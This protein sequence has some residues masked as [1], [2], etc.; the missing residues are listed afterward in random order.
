MIT[1]SKRVWN[2]L[3]WDI[4]HTVIPCKPVFTLVQP[5]P[6]THWPTNSSLLCH[7]ALLC[8][9]QG[10]FP[11]NWSSSF[12]VILA[13]YYLPPNTSLVLAVYHHASTRCVLTIS[14][15]F[16]W[17]QI[18]ISAVMSFLQLP[19]FKLR[20]SERNF[21]PGPIADICNVLLSTSNLTCHLL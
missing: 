18:P 1:V 4:Q 11:S 2:T 12:S 10:Q 5:M 21:C 7:T 20:I 13:F 9:L 17:Q 19:R 16:P 14:I 15:F 8:F 6:K 3:F